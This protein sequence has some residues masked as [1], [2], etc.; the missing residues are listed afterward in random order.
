MRR[1][2]RARL[3]ALRWLRMW[4]PSTSGAARAIQLV[5]LLSGSL[6]ALRHRGRLGGSAGAVL[7]R[8]AHLVDEQA[9]EVDRQSVRVFAVLDP[10]QRGREAMFSGCRAGGGR[11]DPCSG[12]GSQSG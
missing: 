1:A 6:F 2:S 7:V 5:A 8:R 11:D 4:T 10:S 3:N 9:V 12:S